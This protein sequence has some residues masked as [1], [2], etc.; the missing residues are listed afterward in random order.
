MTK[1]KVIKA[2]YIP[3]RLPIV[4]TIVYWL[5]Y[6]ELNL[7]GIGAG[8]YITVV[9]IILAI[10]WIASFVA[11]IFISDPSDPIFEEDEKS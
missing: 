8:I 11:Q 1:R 6:R 5:L 10:G 9:S 4:A 2:K 7:S 3:A